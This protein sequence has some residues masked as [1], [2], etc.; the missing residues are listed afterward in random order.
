[1]RHVHLV[2][3]GLATPAQRRT[4]FVGD[5][6]SVRTLLTSRRGDL[7]LVA[8][9]T[10]L[11]AVAA[12][13]TG[14]PLDRPVTE[15]TT[16]QMPGLAGPGPLAPRR[17]LVTMLGV[18]LLEVLVWQLSGVPGLVLGTGLV[19]AV[20]VAL[21]RSSRDLG[22]SMLTAVLLASFVMLGL[23]TFVPRLRA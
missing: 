8:E 1:M 11:A 9:P 4:P 19:V 22:I 3:T 10:L 5:A 13:L 16:V 14:Q 23:F 21:G 18:V 7:V 20:L 2:P 17:V 12:E 6:A 15:V